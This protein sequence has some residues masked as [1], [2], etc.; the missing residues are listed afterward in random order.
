[1]KGCHSERS[2]ESAVD[3]S[4]SYD[5]RQIPRYCSASLV[6]GLVLAPVAAA[7]A[8]S[9][10]RRTGSAKSRGGFRYSD[11]DGRAVRDRRT[12]ARIARLRVPPAWRDVHIASDPRRAVQAWGY[13]ARH[14]KQYRYHERAVVKRELRKH[15]RVR[16]LARSLPAIRRALRTE[17]HSRNLT[18]D[19]VC[20]IALRLVSEIL[21]RPGSEKYLR[22]NRSHGMTTLTKRHVLVERD[23][24]V[25]EYVGKSKKPQRQ[26]VINPELV[27]LVRRLSRTPG[28]RLFRFRASGGWCDLTGD[29]LM[30]YL[31]GRIGPFAVKDFRTWGGTLRAATVLAELG[32]ARSPTE[33]KRNVAIA[34]RIVASEL[35]N[36][37]AICRSSYVHPMVVARYLDDGETIAIRRGVLR[38][39]QAFAHSPEERA[40]IRFLDKHF[41]ERR[42]KAR[43]PMALAA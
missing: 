22:E 3:I 7:M 37:P 34:M 42:R 26:L 36:T 4:Q 17:S 19:A 27:A 2:E 41:P 33:A 35:G 9:W 20:A 25:F 6:P 16:Q 29:H 39:P 13:D 12:L 10:I 43:V 38:S 18:R 14:R 8:E 23:R 11:S 21:F 28:A 5:D 32:P 40:L 24:A 1:L 15:H 30:E 31:R